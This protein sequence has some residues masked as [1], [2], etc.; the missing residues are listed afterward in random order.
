MS[1]NLLKAPRIYERFT[2]LWTVMYS[3]SCF[4]SFNDVDLGEEQK[5]IISVLIVEIIEFWDLV[6]KKINN[7][8]VY[9]YFNILPQLCLYLSAYPSIYIFQNYLSN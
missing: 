1:G 7:L 9:F 4:H 5:Q 2:Y 8:N 6:S 3:Y